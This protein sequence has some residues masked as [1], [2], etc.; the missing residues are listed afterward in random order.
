M[1]GLSVLCMYV[2]GVLQCEESIHRDAAWARGYSKCNGETKE[3]YVH[4]WVK[5]RNTTS[6]D[7][8]GICDDYV[9]GAYRSWMRESRGMQCNQL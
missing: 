9:Q 7:G 3:H 5:V 6:G 4:D 2:W 1:C 8:D